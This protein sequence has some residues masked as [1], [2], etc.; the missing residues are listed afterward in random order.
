MSIGDQRCSDIDMNGQ[1][2]TDKLTPKTYWS[3]GVETK[4]ISK[5]TKY[6][7]KV[8]KDTSKVTQQTK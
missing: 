2:L 1:I 5:V 4:H 7:L 6:T 3:E 8:T